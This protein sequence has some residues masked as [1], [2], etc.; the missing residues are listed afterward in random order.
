[1]ALGY[2]DSV[3]IRKMVN[4]RICIGAYLIGIAVLQADVNFVCTQVHEREL[5]QG[6]QSIK[7]Q[8]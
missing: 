2:Y 4:I 8:W 3:V 1:M 7:S 5:G 6:T